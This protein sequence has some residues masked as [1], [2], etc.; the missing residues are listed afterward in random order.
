M[1]PPY[2]N[3][4]GRVRQAMT[5]ETDLQEFIP[6]EKEIKGRSRLR[7]RVR[8]K[9]VVKRRKYIKYWGKKKKKNASSILKKRILLSGN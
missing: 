4:H 6:R 7:S 8:I 9:P 2:S 3:S 5:F 1:P